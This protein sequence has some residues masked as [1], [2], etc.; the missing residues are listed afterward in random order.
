MVYGHGVK[1]RN[2]SALPR[3]HAAGNYT[4][5]ILYQSLVGSLSDNGGIS[6]W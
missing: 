5:R 3:A 2:P 6:C 4:G 1:L